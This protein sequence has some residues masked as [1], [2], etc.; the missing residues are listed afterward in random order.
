MNA[1]IE[2]SDTQQRER[3]LEDVRRLLSEGMKKAELS[4]NWELFS[5]YANAY[6][7]LAS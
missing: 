2:T 1:Q 7:S 6:C 3:L 5:R 4:K